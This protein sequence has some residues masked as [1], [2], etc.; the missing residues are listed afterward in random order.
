MGCSALKAAVLQAIES[1][2]HEI[3]E[4]SEAIYNYPETGYKEFQTTKYIAG[5]MEKL[6]CDVQSPGGIPGI[7]ATLDTGRPGP[8][9]PSLRWT[10]RMSRSPAYPPGDGSC[11]RLWAQPASCL[12]AG[13]P[14]GAC[15]CWRIR[16]PLREDALFGGTCRRVHRD[17]LQTGAARTGHHTIPDRQTRVPLQGTI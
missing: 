14:D 8:G 17:Q 7:K 13:G 4:I 11:P 12:D 15:G 6:P 5:K 3:R 16:T 1:K 2:R 9:L 10:F